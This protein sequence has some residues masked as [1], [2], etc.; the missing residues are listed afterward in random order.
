MYNNF[1]VRFIGSLMFPP[2]YQ[3]KNIARSRRAGGIH[4]E[5]TSEYLDGIPS[6]K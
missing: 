2:A 3:M 5:D 4:S 6:Y 1:T